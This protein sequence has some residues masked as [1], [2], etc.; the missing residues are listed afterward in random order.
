MLRPSVRVRVLVAALLAALIVFGLGAGITRAVVAEHADDAAVQHAETQLTFVAEA[1]ASAHYAPTAASVDLAAGA[2]TSWAMSS[3]GQPVVAGGL[4]Q[5]YLRAG[6]SLPSLDPART[7]VQQFRLVFNAI[8]A[9][10]GVECQLAGQ[11]LNVVAKSIPV[12]GTATSLHAFVLIWPFAAAEALATVDPI[13]LVWVPV[14][15]LLVGLLTWWIVGRV[16]RP[17]ERLRHQLVD[18]TAHDLSRRVPVPPT[19]DE[20][21][22]WAQTTNET[23]D[24]LEAAVSRYRS[25][26]DDA[27]HELRSPLASLISTLEVAAA[28]PDQADLPATITAALNDAGRLRRLTDDL[29]LLARLDRGRPADGS[30]VDRRLVDIDALVAEQVAER[31]F[32][33]NGPR[34]VMSTVEGRVVGDEAQLERV[35]RNLLD[36]AARFARGEV[37]VTVSRSPGSI[38]L[39]VL[40]DGP[41][42]AVGDRARVFD[43]FTRLDTARDQ[44][45]GGAGLG[46]AIAR[47][48]VHGHGGQ[49]EIA[50]SPVGARVVVRLPEAVSCELQP[51]AVQATADPAW[52][53]AATTRTGSVRSGSTTVAPAAVS[54][55]AE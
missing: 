18:I 39:E 11:V 55:A 12:P 22:R 28:H 25:F 23:L 45:H 8:P 30:L 21:Q 1:I 24:R 10:V 35:L 27:A 19:G 50:D 20:L 6:Q 3:P 16:L 42:I 43:R 9:C 44:Q 31:R 26:V 17:V 15:V 4:W 14:G 7:G 37:R 33:G 29:L 13:L 51:S 34:Y 41:G 5:K 54:S 49:V 52:S 2:S 32:A 53:T 38:V 48:I 40:D 36:N 47:D 46:L